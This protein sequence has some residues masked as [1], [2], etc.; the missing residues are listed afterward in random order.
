MKIIPLTNSS[1]VGLV[2]DEDWP[3]VAQV[4]WQITVNGYAYH[5]F[6]TRCV[7]LHRFVLGYRGD[8]TVDHINHNKLDNRKE[9]LRVTP[10]SDN[11]WNRPQRYKNNK[12]GV[13][14]VSW[15][16]STDKWQVQ[17]QIRGRRVHLG[18]FHTVEEAQRARD[19]YIENNL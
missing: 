17:I 19:A 5:N 11:L 9:N 8:L 12:S 16:A 10:Y 14:G 13:V 15:S 3:Y 6:G 1:Q 2:D 7:H 18:V 4:N